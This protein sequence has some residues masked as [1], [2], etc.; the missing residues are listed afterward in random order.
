MPKEGFKS[1]TVRADIYDEFVANYEK[2]KKVLALQGVNSLAGFVTFLLDGGDDL[3]AKHVYRPCKGRTKG[4]PC[5][6]PGTTHIAVGREVG[7]A[8]C[9][10]HAKDAFRRYITTPIA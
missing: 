2:Q 3:R 5:P 7:V 4:K 10:E 9:P 6:H 8:L 1:I